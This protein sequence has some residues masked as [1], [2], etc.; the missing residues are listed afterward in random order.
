MPTYNDL[1]E[2]ARICAKN[3]YAAN[4]KE[5]AAELWKMARE[6]QER[7]AKLDSGKLPDI[8]KL[9]PWLE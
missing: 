9:P 2:L 6:Y 7:A 8:G 1:V 4:T 5:V 3:S